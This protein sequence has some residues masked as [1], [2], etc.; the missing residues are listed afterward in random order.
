MG[1][2]VPS[3]GWWY[4]YPDKDRVWTP[5]RIYKGMKPFPETYLIPGVP[6]LQRVDR[7]LVRAQL[8]LMESSR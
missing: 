2:D 1:R 4:Y 6:I 3:P 8:L 5:A 7:D